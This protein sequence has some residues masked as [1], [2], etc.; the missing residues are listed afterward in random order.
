MR[1]SKAVTSAWVASVAM[2][3][4]EIY[5][6]A[7]PCL[8]DV[9]NA[10]PAY[11]CTAGDIAC[12][13]SKEEVVAGFKTCVAAACDND[14]HKVEESIEYGV[15]ACAAAIAGTD[16]SAESDS[17]ADSD[18]ESHSDAE[19]DSHAGEEEEYTCPEQC[20]IGLITEGTA[21][22]CGADNITC[23]CTNEALLLSLRDCAYTCSATEATELIT[24]G[25]DMCASAGITVTL[26]TSDPT[27][28]AATDDATETATGTSSVVVSGDATATASETAV[29]T[30]QVPSGDEG[31]EGAEE[32]DIAV[33]GASNVAAGSY[34]MMTVAGLAA[35]LL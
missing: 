12:F 31:A 10:Q 3:E 5:D 21:A 33:S 2:A 19:S 26:D 30:S 9:L 13:C 17:D 28:G 25:L 4:L 18:S 11:G 7:R 8:N 23:F 6:C 22:G 27:T 35:M 20:L 29:A 34:I 16:P 15:H 14:E 32:D 1:Y 24:Y